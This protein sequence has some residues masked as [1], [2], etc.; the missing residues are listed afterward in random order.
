MVT[1]HGLL[2]S[3]NGVVTQMPNVRI[4]DYRQFGGRLQILTL[5]NQTITEICCAE[6][7]VDQDLMTIAETVFAS[8]AI[9]NASF[10]LNR[11]EPTTWK[12]MGVN[13]HEVK[14]ILH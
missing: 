1:V 8:P 11:H 2:E 7:P 12:H 9:W 6:E 14:Y 4:C 3:F 5:T 10:L 13:L